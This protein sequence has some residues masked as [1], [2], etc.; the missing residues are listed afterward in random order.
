MSRFRAIAAACAVAIVLVLV[1]VL[2]GGG[3]N[4]TTLVSGSALAN[5]ANAT[6]RVQG[7]SFSIDGTVDAE[8]LS[9]PLRIRMRGVQNTRQKAAE[10]VGTYIDFPKQ[11][12][13]RDSNG[14]V[15]I[16]G[17]MVL[18]HMYMK[19][20]LFSAALP[21]GK[22]WIDIDLAKTGRRL[23]IGDPT[24]FGS[25]DPNQSV[26]ALRA[27]SSRVE[28][29]GEEQVRGVAT[30][31]YRATVEL[32]RLPSVT[33]P[34]R[35]AAA[36]QSVSRL[37]QLIGTDSYPME[38]WVDRRHL[39]RRMRI[40]MTMKVQGKSVN[41]DMTIELFDFG[42]KHRIKP[43]PA[44]QTFDASKLAGAGAGP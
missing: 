37:I 20:P 27:L 23:G 12:P 4:D 35:R 7:A 6:E 15:P 24:Q 29:V 30:T 38:V 17:V 8:G 26:R 43:P 11:V 41:Q 31:H 3:G 34:A 40:E 1:L 14:N 32:R 5:A 16:E 10:F 42:P 36:R 19:S 9:Q 18:P 44:D 13:G 33:P 28:R 2:P 21:S 25:A 39:V 22:S